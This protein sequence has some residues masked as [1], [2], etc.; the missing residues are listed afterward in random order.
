MI[1]IIDYK[2]TFLPY[3]DNWIETRSISAKTKEKAIEILKRIE[4]DK[5]YWGGN[6]AIDIL[7]I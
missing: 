3:G 1:Y 5:R 2:K 4:G 6:M 7:K